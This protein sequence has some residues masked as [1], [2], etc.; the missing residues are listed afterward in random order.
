MTH[1]SQTAFKQ[2]YSNTFSRFSLNRSVI[3]FEVNCISIVKSTCEM[4][5]E[6]FVAFCSFCYRCIKKVTMKTQNCTIF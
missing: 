2:N 6:Q 5:Q 3:V 1:C 4:S